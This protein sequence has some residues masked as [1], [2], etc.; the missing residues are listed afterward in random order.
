VIE[1]ARARAKSPVLQ[2][3]Q[4]GLQLLEAIAAENG[5]LTAKQ[6]SARIGTKLGTCYQL[7]HT[8]EEGGY[9]TRV[10]GGCYGVG[11]R[12]AFLQE[13]LRSRLTPAPQLLSILR[14]LHTQV[15]E[16]TYLSGW[17]GEDVVIQWCLESP[18]T[19]HVRSLQVGYSSNPHARASGKAIL[20]LLP[21]SRVHAYLTARGLPRVTAQ[22]ITDVDTML[23]E[24]ETTVQ[25]GFALDREEIAPGVCGVS[26]AYVDH[27]GHPVGAY[28]VTAPRERFDE[29][30][31]E[32]AR[33]VM[34]AAQQASIWLGYTDAYPPRPSPDRPVP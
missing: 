2:T 17:N 26:A 18:H 7:L 8:L 14:H 3:L 4:R 19:L 29:R 27:R 9:V 12:V 34:L 33:V 6:L 24:L 31:D 20:A 1:A 13:S 5:E 25:R 16:T 32:F 28:V 30:C 15:H 10:P 22:T 21:R 11:G 23:D